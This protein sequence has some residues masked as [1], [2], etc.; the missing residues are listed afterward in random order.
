MGEALHYDIP[1]I[2][3]KERE[4]P[5]KCCRE[6]F[7]DWLQTSH[8]AEVGPKVWSTLFDALKDVEIAADIVEEI[9]EKVKELKP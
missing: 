7:K 4:D 1:A 8:G 2:K 6:F 9:I 3:I 5:K